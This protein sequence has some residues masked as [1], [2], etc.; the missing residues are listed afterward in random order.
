MKTIKLFAMAAVGALL[1][2]S[3]TSELEDSLAV[4]STELSVSNEGGELPLNFTTNTSWTIECDQT[5]V[6]FDYVSGEAGE[7]T[8]VAT[9]EAND[10]YEAREAVIT[11]AAGSKTTV[12]TVKQGYSVEFTSE[13]VYNVSFEAPFAISC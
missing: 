4:A 8:V 11:I 7:N 13:V 2:L 1:A 5:W 3:C 10:T 9:V 12:F 6:S